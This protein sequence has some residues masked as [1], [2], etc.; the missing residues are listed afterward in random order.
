MPY[1][2][3]TKDYIDAEA[4]ASMKDGVRILNFARGEIVNSDAIIAAV[5]SGKVA[6]YVTDFAN[7][8]QL[9][10][11]NIVAIPHLGASTPESEDNCARM[12]ADQLKSFLTTGN[13]RNS[14]NYPNVEAD[15]AGD[16]R[17]VILHKNEPNM[18]EKFTAAVAGNNIETL[19]NKSKKDYSCTIMDITGQF[20]DEMIAKINAVPGV[21]RTIR[22]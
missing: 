1:L 12:A 7:D 5:K 14:V 15:I 18:I 22:I 10:V 8:D 21:I 9:C 2:P 4:I 6:A 3:S 16:S 13:I 20:N 17:I 11:D 19:I